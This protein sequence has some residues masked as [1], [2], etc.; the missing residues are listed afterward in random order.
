MHAA[1][2]DELSLRP[3]RRVAG[4]L[5]RVTGHVGELD[6]LVALVVVA[7]HEDAP[8]QC[9]LGRPGPLDEAGVAGRRQVAGTVDA[10]FGGWV[11]APAEQE[12]RGRGAGWL[13]EGCHLFM[14]AQHRSGSTG[15]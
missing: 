15:V 4:Q 11:A 3:G 2:D 9:R 14:L 1:E 10:A 5:E 8:P 7:Q 12:Q 6:D 13:Y